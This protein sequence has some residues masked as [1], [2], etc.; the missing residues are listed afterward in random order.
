MVIVFCLTI[1]EAE[2]YGEELSLYF[3][4]QVSVGHSTRREPL[5][6]IAVVTSC[7]SHGV[8]IPGLTHVMIMR[9]TWSIEGFVQVSKSKDLVCLGLQQST[10]ASHE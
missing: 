3:P 6:R 2:D 5:K 4:E 7:F 8:N 9:S 1:Q 10:V